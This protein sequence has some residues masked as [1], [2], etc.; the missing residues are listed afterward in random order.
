MTTSAPITARRIPERQRAKYV[1]KLFGAARF[2]FLESFVFD[3]ASSLS[4]AY[5]GGF[6]NFFAL[7][8]GGFFMAPNAPAKFEVAAFNGFEGELSAEAFGIAVTLS[9][10]S[11]LSFN[12]DEKFSELCA[13]QYYL[14]RDYMLSHPEAQQI[15]AVLD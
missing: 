13:K 12:P 2:I 3:T 14:L 7:S 11:L 4:S 5:S 10:L 9:A 1:H 6:W 8:N 15:L